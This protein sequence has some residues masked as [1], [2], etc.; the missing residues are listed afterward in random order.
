MSASQETGRSPKTM[1]FD[2]GSKKDTDMP[3]RPP[4]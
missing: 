3:H 4:T 1:P 2:G